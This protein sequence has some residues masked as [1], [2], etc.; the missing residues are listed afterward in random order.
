VLRKIQLLIVLGV[1]TGGVIGFIFYLPDILGDVFY[2]LP[3]NEQLEAMKQAAKEFSVPVTLVVAVAKHESGFREKALSPAGA[4]GIMQIIPG[5]GAGLARELNITDFTVNTL[6]DPTFNIRLGTYY[7]SRLLT[8]YNGDLRST[9]A[10]YNAG[11]RGPD[12]LGDPNREARVYRGV[13]GYARR[14]IATKNIYEQLYG[15]NLEGAKPIIK[16]EESVTDRLK[17]VKDLISLILK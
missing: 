11:P 14:V 10:H 6:Y 3:P 5:T 16:P 2:P 13:E 17:N 8:K 12:L 1:I 4:R 7:L 9:L 15:S